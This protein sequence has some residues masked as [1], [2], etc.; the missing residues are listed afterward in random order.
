MARAIWSV[1]RPPSC[2]AWPRR[3]CHSRAWGQSGAYQSPR[4]LRAVVGFRFWNRESSTENGSRQFTFS[5]KLCSAVVI[6]GMCTDSNE[7]FSL[8]GFD[9]ERIWLRTVSLLLRASLSKAPFGS[10]SVNA[11]V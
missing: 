11:S 8:E 2:G 6:T 9:W 7:H 10:S 4:G 3:S 5:N 1:M